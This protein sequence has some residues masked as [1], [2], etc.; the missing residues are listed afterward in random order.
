ME[1]ATRSTVD[2]AIDTESY[3]ERVAAGL[4][5]PDNNPLENCNVLFHQNIIASQP[6]GDKVR[7][8]HSETTKANCPLS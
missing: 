4:P 3:R 5:D 8:K 6:D 2:K 1:R 7:R